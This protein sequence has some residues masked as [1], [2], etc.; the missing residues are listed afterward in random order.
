MHYP[1]KKQRHS[2][3]YEW[4]IGVC[5]VLNIATVDYS[6]IS[7]VNARNRNKVLAVFELPS[8]T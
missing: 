4:D 1:Y 5:F 6:P 7:N 8:I 3:T 2:H